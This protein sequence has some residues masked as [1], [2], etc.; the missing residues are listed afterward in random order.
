MPIYYGLVA[1]KQNIIL[2]EFTEYNG[3][4][5]QI[6][7]QLMQRV[8][9]DTKKTF[10]LEDFLFHYISEDGLTVM[11][12]TDKAIQKKIAFAFMQDVRK[13]LIS[14]YS[15]RELENAKA[16]GLSTFTDK[17]REKMTYYNDNPIT[18]NDK[19]DELM[20][21]LN[22][23]K[24][25]MV[26]NIDRL[27]ERDGKIEVILQKAE[28]LSTYSKTYRANARRA[29]N[30]MRNRRIFYVCMLIII[31][32]LVGFFIAVIACGGFSFHGCSSS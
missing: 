13:T 17:I 25:S 28:S 30:K 2:A 27:I 19:T 1:K 21:E 15:P 5:Q 20:R 9:P 24:D 16:Y 32:G 3:N 26:E 14:S 4:F 31:L 6:T 29:K 10:E 8:V 7:M 22:G 12:M 23:L 18:I 11:C